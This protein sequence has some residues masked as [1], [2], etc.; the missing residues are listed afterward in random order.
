[1]VLFVHLELP[2]FE[3]PL[4]QNISSPSVRLRRRGVFR[5]LHFT[6]R[7][8]K[9]QTLPQSRACLS[10]AEAFPWVSLISVYI[11]VSMNNSLNHFSKSKLSGARHGESENASAKAFQTIKC[12]FC[13]WKLSMCFAN[14]YTC[15]QGVLALKR[16]LKRI[17]ENRDHLSAD[18]WM[19]CT[20]NEFCL[21]KVHF[22]IRKECAQI[23]ITSMQ[24]CRE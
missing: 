21:Y 17:R 4:P 20:W 6:E 11:S 12:K 16:K 7:Q 1:M 3:V 13:I 22:P 10:R 24:L 5:S 23:R 8:P 18:W 15:F 19:S 2:D 14:F 9:I